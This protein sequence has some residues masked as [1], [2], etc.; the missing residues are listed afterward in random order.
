MDDASGEHSGE[1]GG[2]EPGFEDGLGEG[3]GGEEGEEGL[4]E[5]GAGPGH[6]GRGRNLGWWMKGEGVVLCML[7]CVV[8]L[9]E[10]ITEPDGLI[11]FVWWMFEQCYA[12]RCPS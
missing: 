11:V 1:V 12:A 9:D 2:V 7:C 10:W 8:P 5:A 4:H 3:G 6:F